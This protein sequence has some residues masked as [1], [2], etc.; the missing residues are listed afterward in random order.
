MGIL[1]IL[2]KFIFTFLLLPMDFVTIGFRVFHTLSGN[3]VFC[4]TAFS[5]IWRYH[6]HLWQSAGWLS[7]GG[8]GQAVCDKML[9]Q[10]SGHPYDLWQEE[11]K[12]LRYGLFLSL[13]LSQIRCFRVFCDKLFKNCHRRRQDACFVTI[14]GMIVTG[15]SR[16][17]SLVT[18]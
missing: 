9:S 1:P 15:H 13:F 3:P 17:L 14:E 16:W 18:L 5:Q 11:G 2:F 4:E 8:L 12:I 10:D 6:C 7:L